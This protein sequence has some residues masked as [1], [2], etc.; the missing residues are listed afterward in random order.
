MTRADN[1]VTAKSQSRSVTVAKGDSLWT[2]AERHLGSGEQWRRIAALNSGRTMAGG[3]TFRDNTTLQPGWTLLIPS[4]STNT[5][6]QAADFRAAHQVTVE[7][8]DSLWSLSEAAY[9]DGEEWGRLYDANRD[10]ITDPDLIYPQQQ[11]RVPATHPTHP[12]TATPGPTQRQ[13]AETHVDP[14]PRE[15]ARGPASPPPAGQP[16]TPDTRTGADAQDPTTTHQ[17]RSSDA[18]QQDDD[19]VDAATMMRALGG[20]GLLLA[21]GVFTA[22]LARRRRQFRNRRSGHTIT[23]TPQDL[24][25]TERAVRARGSAGGAAA[26][27]LDHALR[28]LAA[29]ARRGECDLP[30]VAAARLS[31]TALELVVTPTETVAPTP[32]TTS[33]DGARW[34]LSR[35]IEFESTDAMAPYPTLVAVGLDDAERHLAD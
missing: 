32:W 8:G 18:T 27:F 33:P 1:A 26:Q 2:L 23:P 34:Q 11:L 31:E 28:D 3:Q 22:L 9:G 30:E 7:P 12:A 5:A 14:I 35:D 16:T 10:H 4:T 24:V 20:G 6:G 15:T 17:T 19:I 13:P 25:P 29:R 21:S